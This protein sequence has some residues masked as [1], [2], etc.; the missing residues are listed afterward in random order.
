MHRPNA[1]TLIEL[2]VVIA[3]IAILASLTIPSIGMV[4]E[5]TRRVACAS[6]LRN[7]VIGTLAYADDNEGRGFNG[8]SSNGA[9]QGQYYSPAHQGIEQYLM[10]KIQVNNNQFYKVMRCPSIRNIPDG[11]N[12]SYRCGT[13]TDYPFTLDRLQEYM[14]A[15]NQPGDQLPLWSDNFVLFN[16][17]GGPGSYITGCNHKKFQTG[18]SSGIPAGGNTGFLDGSVRWLHYQGNV[19]PTELSIIVSGGA[20]GSWTGVP[21]NTVWFRLEHLGNLSS[22]APNVAIGRAQYTWPNLP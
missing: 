21:S 11:R 6:N 15:A 8:G 12:Y 9:F 17:G 7:L 14:H 2:L 3:I 18:P 19:N 4:R 1:F 16:T 20:I 10:D 13:P 5:Q 22:T